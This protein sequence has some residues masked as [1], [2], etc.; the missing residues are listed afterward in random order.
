MKISNFNTIIAAS[1]LV[2]G[3]TSCDDFLDQ[4]S[5]DTYNVDNYYQ[6]DT[7]V[8]AG[9]NYIYNSPWYDFQRGFI[10]VGEVLSG[11]YYW[12][13]SPY[14]TFT[15][16][17]S[18]EDLVNM[19]C[20]LWAVIGHSNVVY[21]KIAAATGT[22][23]EATR[24]QALGECLTL[25]AL[26]YFFLVRSFGDVP[27][28]HDTEAEL[29]SGT[30]NELKKVH[31]SDVYEYI[32]MTLEEAMK[33]LEGVTN[34]ATSGRVDYYAAEGLLAKVYLTKAGVSGSLDADDLE[35]AATYAKD[36]MDNSGR[37]LM[38]TYSD[39]FRMQNNMS[40]E[41]LIAWRWTVGSQWTCQNTLQSD[42]AISGFSDFGDCWG[43][44]CGLSADIQEEWGVKLYENSDAGVWRNNVDDRLKATMMLPG[45]A[46]EYFWTD[47]TYDNLV[48]GKG[49]GFSYLQFIFDTD[50]NS[51][52]GTLQSATGANCVKHLYGDTY[53]HVQALGI[54][55]ANMS[56]ALATHVLRLSDIYLVY[57]EAKLG[58]G[59]T[60]R[61]TT[62]ADA[63]DA[64]YQ[65]RH[66]AINNYEK[67][68]SIS[69]EDIWTERRLEFAM[70]GDRW[71]DFVRV[72][73]YDPD[74]TLDVLRNQKRNAIW[75]LEDQYKD[76][77]ETGSWT[78]TGN[79]TY[80]SYTT[81]P[82]FTSLMR[83]DADS[84]K[85]YFYIPM[86]SEDVVYNP[87]LASNIDGEHVDVRSTYSY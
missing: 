25:K 75:N 2:L 60:D 32:I 59:G 70:E 31:K 30:Y 13:S 51:G 22:V 53:D 23:T 86:S 11:N 43:G 8:L 35:K 45:F 20:S 83:K 28:I 55:P 1:L 65:V 37:S 76:F 49:T 79:V 56:Y 39:I 19:S 7:Q 17:G 21:N 42:L 3:T 68:S 4:P 26:A 27:I 72:S 63:I 12:G 18:D 67:P 40:D 64:F 33:D 14:L 36:V 16:N 66:R 84:G 87:N 77:Y 48:D 54:S 81:Q 52:A 71:Y 24:R 38:D 85:M 10:K 44:Y 82:D 61:S 15:L 41:S 46:Y 74:F 69:F 34:G 9:V 6:N 62:D 5:T 29:S 47:R 50:Y 57:A 58:T 78:P 73:Y 80:D